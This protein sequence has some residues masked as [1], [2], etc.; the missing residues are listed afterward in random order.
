MTMHAETEKDQ[1]GR[2][3]SLL[4]QMAP[5]CVVLLIRLFALLGHEVTMV[6]H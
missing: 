3:S 4:L 1:Q 6:K 5:Q 2:T